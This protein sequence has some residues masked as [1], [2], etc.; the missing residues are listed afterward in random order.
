MPINNRESKFI[1]ASS[2]NGTAQWL[3]K[4]N[5]DSPYLP[6]RKHP[7]RISKDKIGTTESK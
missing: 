1:M 2:Q 6:L 5:E 3:F 7:Q 4:E